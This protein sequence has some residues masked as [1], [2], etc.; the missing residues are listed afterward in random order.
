MGFAAPLIAY[1]I[2]R[3]GVRFTLFLGSL[4]LICGATAMATLMSRNWH[5]VIFFGIVIGLGT[6][7]GGILP[8]Q[9]CVTLW[10]RL[11]RALAISLVLTAAGIGGFVA[12]PLLNRIIVMA[13]GDWR[14]GWFFVAALSAVSALL[15]ILWVRNRP[16]DLGQFPD[17]LSEDTKRQQANEKGVGLSPKGIHRSMVDWAVRDAL[18]SRTMYLIILIGVCFLIPFS[19]CIAH[20]VLH[21][22]DLGHKPNTA[23]MSVGILTLFSIVGRLLGGALGD[24]VEPRFPFMAGMVLM[25]LGCFVLVSAG[26]TL[27]VYLYAAFVGVGFGAGLVCFS[28]MIANYYGANSFASIQAVTFPVCTAVGAAAPFL[29]GLAYDRVGNYTMGLKGAGIAA[30]IAAAALL[31][32][33]PP[34]PLKEV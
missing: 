8:V 24:R 20:G 28:A 25:G 15:S 22:N 19:V 11:K 3:K 4:I 14:V 9:T 27:A 26:S 30:L 33:I 29:V 7:F 16:E 6:G 18:R 34:K 31:F 10:F 2:N 5:Y 17:G 32:T 23:A 12:A 21:L 13:D 1:F